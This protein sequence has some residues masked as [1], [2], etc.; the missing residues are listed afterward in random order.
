METK[1]GADRLHHKLLKGKFNFRVEKLQ[2]ENA[3]KKKIVNT[4]QT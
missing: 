1:N 2:R 4:N 3:I